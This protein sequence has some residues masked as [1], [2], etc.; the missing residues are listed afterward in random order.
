M[1]TAIHYMVTNGIQIAHILS[2]HLPAEIVAVGQVSYPLQCH[3]IQALMLDHWW[4]EV[5]AWQ[6]CM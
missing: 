4:V 3:C 2:I 6:G 1:A 5:A